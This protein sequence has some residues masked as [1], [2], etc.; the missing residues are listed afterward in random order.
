MSDDPDGLASYQI[1]RAAQREIAVR[2]RL[3]GYE[4]LPSRP[5]EARWAQEGPCWEPGEN[6]D[7]RRLETVRDWLASE[8]KTPP[9]HE[10]PTAG[11]GSE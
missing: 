4:P 2:S 1:G 11:I 7:F 10:T 9:S 3:P 8:D 5:H 6:P